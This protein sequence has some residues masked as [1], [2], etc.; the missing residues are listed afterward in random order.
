MSSNRYHASRTRTI[1]AVG[2]FSALAYVAVVLFHF[3]ASF[4]T[5]DLKDAVMT[6]GAMLFGPVYGLAMSL[7]VSLL[8]AVT[9]S[10]TGV[11][12]FIMNVL[13]SVTF[14]CL[15]SLIYTR[16]RTLSGAVLGMLVSIFGMTAV[17]MAANLIITPF[18]L[19][20]STADVAAI[21]PTLLLPFNLTK[22]LFNAALVFL[23]YKPIAGA[24]KAAGFVRGSASDLSPDA[25]DAKRFRVSP[26]VI[27]ALL[28]GIAALA[29]F[30]LVLKG[31]FSIG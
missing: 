16:R 30:F 25:A 9:I 7:I 3:K 19:G 2:V 28:V 13:S 26:A 14:V 31:S 24:L 21:I 12:G 1:V 18:Y 15:G 11:Y 22:A 4:L 5:F 27:V 20:M 23:F 6:I 17:M 29:Y 8:E 10:S